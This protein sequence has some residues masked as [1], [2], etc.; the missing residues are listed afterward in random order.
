MC[1]ILHTC[2]EKKKAS[3]CH[4][5]G[6]LNTALSIFTLMYLRL[7]HLDEV[8]QPSSLTQRCI[9]LCSATLCLSRYLVPCAFYL[10]PY[11]VNYPTIIMELTPYTCGSCHQI[12]QT[13]DNLTALA[14]EEGYRHH[15]RQ[16]PI[17][18]ATQ[19]CQLCKYMEHNLDPLGR[20]YR[21]NFVSQ[22]RI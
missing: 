5:T 10:S 21:P 20:R 1:K 8:L 3:A 11:S 12:F 16:S 15:D 13:L 22:S 18:S 2:C 4:N 19:G 7:W 9:W 6:L 17:N 14:A